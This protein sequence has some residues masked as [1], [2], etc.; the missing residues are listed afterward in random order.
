MA[1][2]YKKHVH[3]YNAY[4]E[5]MTEYGYQNYT[6]DL[7]AVDFGVP[8][9][10]P[11]TFCVSILKNANIK[12]EWLSI[13]KQPVILTDYIDFNID[14]R[15]KVA[16]IYQKM[17]EEFEGLNGQN[18]E[19]V[20]LT[21]QSSNFRKGKPKFSTTIVHCLCCRRDDYIKYSKGNYA[22]LTGKE[23]LKLQGF[24]DIECI[25]ENQKHIVAGNSINVN[26]L[27]Y[28]FSCF[29]NKFL[30]MPKQNRYTPLDYNYQQTMLL[31]V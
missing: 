28:I 21:C 7:N 27:K 8:Q 14:N 24:P 10:R 13:Y 29:G 22:Y 6:H 1:V 2:K 4:L 11:R 12:F 26:V 5:Q 3:N 30:K 17:V 31:A 18:M 9:N 19:N 23:K 15:N 20:I 25:N 16:P